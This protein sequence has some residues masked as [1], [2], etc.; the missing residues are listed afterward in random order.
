MP[1]GAPPESVWV[2]CNRFDC[3]D[4]SSGRL[5]ERLAARW[6][7]RVFDTIVHRDDQVESY[8][9]RGVPVTAPESGVPGAELYARLADETLARLH[10]A[11]A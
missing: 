5:Y 6:G 3:R 4:Y 10:L 8:S 11:C 9:E 1:C 2:V 7:G